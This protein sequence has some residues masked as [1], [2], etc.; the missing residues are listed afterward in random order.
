[1]EEAHL[2]HGINAPQAALSEDRKTLPIDMLNPSDSEHGFSVLYV[3]RSG[4]H[5]DLRHLVF[6]LVECGMAGT[7]NVSDGSARC[8]SK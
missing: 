7:P 3:R 6:D 2:G 8:T 1:M 4:T 5:G